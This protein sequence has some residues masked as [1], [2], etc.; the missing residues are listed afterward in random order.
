MSGMRKSPQITQKM[1]LHEAGDGSN[2]SIELRCTS[3]SEPQIAWLVNSAQVQDGGKYK[4]VFRKEGGADTYYASLTATGT[5]KNT[6]AP[7]KYE[8]RLRN[9]AGESMAWIQ[10]FLG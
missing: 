3:H 8:V 4:L 9:D 1:S 6:S 5:T 2:L 7:T 10:S